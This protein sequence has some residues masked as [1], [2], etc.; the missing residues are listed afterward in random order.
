MSTTTTT[1]IATHETLMPTIDEAFVSTHETPMPIVAT[2]PVSPYEALMSTVASFHEPSIHVVPFG[3]YY[4]SLLIKLLLH[5][6][7]DDFACFINSC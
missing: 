3:S 1:F 5:L 6:R 7:A 2:V 4:H